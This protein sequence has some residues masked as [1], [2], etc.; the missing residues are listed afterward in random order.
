MMIVQEMKAIKIKNT[1]KH[2]NPKK[3]KNTKT[4]KK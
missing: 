4:Q 1:K 2:K 3:I